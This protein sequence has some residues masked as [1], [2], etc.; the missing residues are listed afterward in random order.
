MI[1]ECI[2]E[3]FVREILIPVKV[4]EVVARFTGNVES[5]DRDGNFLPEI[6]ELPQSH[7]PE[8]VALFW[9]NRACDQ[10][11]T[12]IARE[13]SNNRTQ[14]LDPNPPFL[15]SLEELSDMCDGC[16]IFGLVAFY[17]VNVVS[18]RS[19]VLKEN[20]SIADSIHNLQ[21]VQ[22]FC[23]Q[24]L[25]QHICFLTLEDFLYLPE[26]LIR[27]FLAFIADLLYV[28]EIQPVDCVQAPC[29]RIDY[30]S[31]YDRSMLLFF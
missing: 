24:Y 5:F 26:Q 16:S 31:D 18:W 6:S 23:L 9:I 25:P 17:C 14:D 27:N 12:E 2:L 20:I 11:N 13:Y 21:K 4:G 30:D 19:I 7:D 28:F 10:F 8:T 1:V 29:L 15:P 22:Q 3:L